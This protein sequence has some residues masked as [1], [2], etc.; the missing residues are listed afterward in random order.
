MDTSASN[1]RDPNAYNLLRYDNTSIT[2]NAGDTNGDNIVM[3]LDLQHAFI[4][5][6]K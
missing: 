2:L 1:F 4:E 6:F 3:Q 5:C